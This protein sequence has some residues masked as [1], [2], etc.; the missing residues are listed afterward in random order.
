MLGGYMPAVITEIT[1]KEVTV[2]ANHE[3]A[4][5]DLIFDVTIKNII[6]TK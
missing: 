4:G 6:P 1:D 3:L 5:K 2:D